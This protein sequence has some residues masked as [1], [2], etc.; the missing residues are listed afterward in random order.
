MKR[1]FAFIGVFVLLATVMIAN[2]PPTDPGGE[3]EHPTIQSYLGDSE[4]TAILGS[5]PTAYHVL[6]NEA[7]IQFQEETPPKYLQDHTEWLVGVLAEHH[8]ASGATMN[9]PGWIAHL[10]ARVG[11]SNAFTGILHIA[12]EVGAE[13]SA[14]GAWKTN[15]CSNCMF[16][17]A[18]IF[19][20]TSSGRHMVR[21]VHW[22]RKPNVPNQFT[23]VSVHVP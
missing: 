23:A 18:V 20:P 21:G 4:E 11:Y 3:T 5:L 17:S 22:A 14:D 15:T 9:I 13:V 10:Y 7:F 6:A 2:G 16:V 19:K 8:A 12:G 1:K